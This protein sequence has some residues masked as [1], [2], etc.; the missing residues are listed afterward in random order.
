MTRN[1]F[2]SGHK[3][4]L[5]QSSDLL[6]IRTDGT[7]EPSSFFEIEDTLRPLWYKLILVDHLEQPNIWVYKCMCTTPEASEKLRSKIKEILRRF[8]PSGLI[9]AGTVFV[10]ERGTYQLYTENIFIKFWDYVSRAE[11]MRYFERFNLSLKRDLLF[12]R[13]GFFV[14]ASGVGRNVFDLSVDLL[15]QPAVELC[16]PELVVQKKNFPPIDTLQ[17]DDFLDKEWVR[18]ILHLD[19]AWEISRGRGVTICVIDDGLD[20]Y[21]PAFTGDKI[22][23][24]R[25]MYSNDPI[26]PEH[27]FRSEGHGTA[28]A[29]I[30]CS[31]D[32]NALGVAPDA[33]LL[34][35]RINE[36]GSVLISDAIYFAVENGADIISCSWGPEDG[37]ITDPADDDIQYD[38]PDH[39]RLAIDYAVEKGR[40]GKGCLVFFAAGNGRELIIYDG[41]AS[42]KNVCAIGAVNKDLELTQYSDYG[43]EMFCTFPSSEIAI[44]KDHFVILY[45]GLPAADRVGISGYSVGDYFYLFGGTSAACPGVAGVAALILALDS[46]LSRDEVL[47]IIASTCDKI[48]G[49]TIYDQN[50]LSKKFGYGLVQPVQALLKAQSIKYQKYKSMKNKGISLHIGINDYS[51]FGGQ[52]NSLSGCV[53]DCQDMKSIAKRLGYQTQVL[54]DQDATKENIM[55]GIA[56]MAGEVESGD[57]VLI[58]YA[59]HGSQIPDE[60]GDEVEDDMDE[61]WISFDDFIL[62]DELREAFSKFKS[63]VRIL[64]V[65]DSCHSGTISRMIDP[66]VLIKL[67]A[68]LSSTR[69]IRYVDPDITA[70]LFK[71]KR[72]RGHNRKLPKSTARGMGDDPKGVVQA[73]VK[74]LHACQDNQVALEEDGQGIFTRNL[75]LKLSGNSKYTYETLIRAIRASMNVDQTPGVN[76]YGKTTFGDDLDAFLISPGFVPEPIIDPILRVPL[77][78]DSL[79]IDY[80]NGN[81]DRTI[82]SDVSGRSDITEEVRPIWDHAY[83]KYAELLQQGKDVSFVEPDNV[84]TLYI[85]P[86]VED[87][88]RSGQPYLSTYPNPKDAVQ[89]FIWHLDDDHSQLRRANK[90]V[91]PDFPLS[92][93][94]SGSLVRIAHIDTGIL[95]LDE[96]KNPILPQYFDESLSRSFI[97]G[98]L[99]QGPM[100]TDN[101]T[102]F[103]QDGHGNATLAILAG[104]Q[105]SFKHTGNRYRGHFGAIP[106]ARV[107]SLR[108]SETVVLFSGRRFAEALR[109]AVDV[110]KADVVTMSM[111]GTP[112]L[113]MVKAI[114]YA[115]EKGVVIVSA[116][117]NS[118]SKSI[119]N[120]TPK[121]TLYPARFN[122]VISAVGATYEHQPYLIEYQKADGYRSEGSLYQQTC[123]GGS[124]EVLQTSIA[125]Y[126]P[127]ISWANKI[128]DQDLFSLRGGGTSSATPQVAAAA[129]LYIQKYRDELDK[130]KPFEK[131]EAVRHALFTSAQKKPHYQHV[132]G[133]GLLRAAE[134]LKIEPIQ[135]PITP[136]DSLGW[137]GLDETVKLLFQ[138]NALQFNHQ[139][140][141]EMIAT[142]IT[143][144]AM[145]DKDFQ[146]LVGDQDLNDELLRKVYRSAQASS[147]LKRVIAMKLGDMRSDARGV[148][149]IKSEEEV[150]PLWENQKEIGVATFQVSGLGQV[151]FLAKDSESLEQM[152]DSEVVHL[153]SITYE[154]LN[155][156]SA[157]TDTVKISHSLPDEV[158]VM[159][160]KH[161]EDGAIVCEWCDPRKANLSGERSASLRGLISP[162]DPPN[163]IYIEL[164]HRPISRDGFFKNILKKVV[165]K[166]FK[167][168]VKEPTPTLS[169][170]KISSSGNKV[171]SVDLVEIPKRQAQE[172]STDFNEGE[173]LIFI[174]GTFSTVEKSFS[175]LFVNQEFLQKVKSKYKLILAY[176]A[177]TVS[178]GVEANISDLERRLRSFKIEKVDVIAFSRGCL[179]ARG[180]LLNNKQIRKAALIAGP[181][182]GTPLA[183]ASK[184]LSWV[185]RVSTLTTMVF[186]GVNPV[187]KVISF[188]LKN[189]YTGVTELDGIVDQR[190]DSKFLV[191]INHQSTY[192]QSIL[193]IG[194]DF[195][196]ETKIYRKV[197]DNI[198]DFGAFDSYPNDLVISLQSALGKKEGRQLFSNILVLQQEEI[199]HFAY[200]R[201]DRVIDALDNHFQ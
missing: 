43:Y 42:Y 8:Q 119:K 200:F 141:L 15:N 181:H 182:W 108:I 178:L 173:V 131:V 172:R 101:N 177:P 60:D 102:P 157:G 184:I 180:L 68:G 64:L 179:V 37:L 94:N 130:L 104:N 193:S 36:I 63:G 156:R 27:R 167:W 25:D 175:D 38:L 109:Y 5:H 150:V 69:K 197:L 163:A 61:L 147:F 59:G 66:L 76:N 86:E 169:E 159:V 198:L 183:T 133:Q 80:E 161:L 139:G 146:Q 123:Y 190:E 143:Q 48:G 22:G 110:V 100:D 53:N 30:A 72:G 192:D 56:R 122:R 67:R 4:S 97:D 187:I 82:I 155:T 95:S 186:G 71:Q 75:K 32:P 136:S 145:Q 79:L 92:P 117:G 171:L 12:T 10:T 189:V 135:R 142:E 105:V 65:S 121:T 13:N 174:P 191:K 41:Y 46:D 148:E 55:D 51:S 50:G 194:S 112:S 88:N 85:A 73:G 49:P 40:N 125:A 165:F 44:R 162:F 144:I 111:A 90:M 87:G 138:R 124:P 89:P 154:P 137:F 134:A 17:I 120:L 23:A 78:V 70:R 151:K 113:R 129:A 115:Y 188:I 84:S 45:G 7:L 132:F 201:N 114:N 31:R 152:D 57:I 39:I 9:F 6:A 126:T 93:A 81:Q 99:I 47:E 149:S 19:E 158:Y 3:Y 26:F 24:F 128:G 91:F 98:N 58:T 29:S 54:V 103:E 106:W 1:F 116:A 166:L 160:E 195:E 199:H 127:N 2:Y 14:E 34:P 153:Q 164:N 96:D 11:I 35:I 196:A 176:D 185:N 140:L 52:I 28:C 170:L 74:L 83:K 16:H 118:W 33:F 21:H 77:K 20:M 168:I 18:D 62:D 107:S